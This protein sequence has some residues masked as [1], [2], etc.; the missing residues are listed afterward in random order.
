M[1]ETCLNCKRNHI[2]FSGK[3]VKKTE[4]IRMARQS[5]R[6]QLKERETGGGT[7]ANRTPLGIR[8]GRDIRNEAGEPMADGK[9]D[10]TWEKA[11]AEEERDVT[12]TETSGETEMRA[13]ASN[14]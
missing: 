4:A 6:M 3:C 5:R 8:Q 12:I 1:Q 7:G 11:V 14:D 13:A 10:D 9:A 2:A